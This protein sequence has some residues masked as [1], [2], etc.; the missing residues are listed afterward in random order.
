MPDHTVV[1]NPFV[2]PLA[3]ELCET[4]FFGV[5]TALFAFSTFFMLRKGLSSRTR[6]TMLV[7]SV[8]MYAAAA[9][10]WALEIA[11]TLRRSRVG[12]VFLTPSEA[13]ALIYL[14]AV[15]YF[16]SDSIVLWRAWVLWNRSAA[17][18]YEGMTTKSVRKMTMSYT[19]KWCIWGFTIS[20]NLW[21]TC[22]IFIR[23]WQHRRFLRSQFSNG[24]GPSKAESALAFLVESGAFYFCIWLTFVLVAVLNS[25]VVLFYRTIIVE[26][27]GIYPTAIFVV[28]TMRMSAADILSYPGLDTHCHPSNMVFA[29]PPP[30]AQHS[31][32]VT[33]TGSSSDRDSLVGSREDKSSRTLASS[34]PEKGGK[35]VHD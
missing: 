34:D 27:V 8:V 7:V 31:I 1:M 26:L 35:I 6:N 12:N 33:A 24:N 4:F 5:Y 21:S 29:R 25:P 2:P 23:A 32:L 17:F 16:L 20:T 14:P 10:H 9:S 3:A 13:L 28:V 11:V 22:L 15:N 30:T 18:A 19:L